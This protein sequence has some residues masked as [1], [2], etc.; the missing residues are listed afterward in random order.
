MDKQLYNIKYIAIYLT[1]TCCLASFFALVAGAS[2]FKAFEL[3]MASKDWQKTPDDQLTAELIT[4]LLE[5][6]SD[7]LW[8]T[9]ACAERIVNDAEVSQVLVKTGLRRSSR[10]IESIKGSLVSYEHIGDAEEPQ[11]GQKEQ[12]VSYF[13]SHERERKLCIL[14]RLL[15]DRLDRIQT[16]LLMSNAWKSSGTG[17][18]EEAEEEEDPWADPDED[19]PMPPVS[20]APFTLAEF[21]VQPLVDSGIILASEQRFRALDLL[22]NYHDQTI[23]PYRYSILDAI[24]LYVHP[25]EYHHLLPA[26]DYDTS[27]EVRETRKPWREKVDWVEEREVVDAVNK[28]AS[29]EEEAWLEGLE[30]PEDE[31]FPRTRHDKLLT[32]E[33]LT[34]WYTAR[35][36]SIDSQSGL[37]DN[38]LIFLQHGASQSVPGLDELGED[39]ILLDRL[40]YEAPQP[41]TAM[42]IDWDLPRWRQMQP[43]EV[44]RAYLAYSTYES[45]P[46]DI[47]SLVMPYLSVLE[48]QAERAKRPD[49][50]LATRLLYDYILEAPLELVVAI[51]EHS[52]ADV[53]RSYRIIKTDEDVAR[54]AMAYLYGLTKITDWPML[55]RIFECQPDWGDEREDDDEAFA[56]LTSLATFVAP[57]ASRASATAQELLL[58]FKPLPA[59]ALSRLL[60]VL[61]THLEGGEILSKWG[62]DTPLQWFLLSADNEAEQRSRAVRMSRRTV[63]QGAELEDEASWRTLFDDMIKLTSNGEGGVKPAFGRLSPAEI[64]KIFFTGLLSSGSTL[65]SDTW[66]EGILTSK[67]DFAVAKRLKGRGNVAKYLTGPVVEEICLNVS[68]ELYDNASSGNMHRGDMKLA[69][70][71]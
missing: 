54:V 52:K 45:I 55:S 15:F 43:R 5:D 62:V 69:Y 59:S 32:A 22:I 44:I 10:L 50:E 23:F 19:I 34:A 47:R 37:L 67:P 11:D 28:T 25:S 21:L 26:N 61:D 60:D 20:D 58:F 64:S 6:I 27:V 33:Q 41:D 49:L 12:L 46:S 30:T 51:F 57:S 38:A 71:W 39:L 65:F 4:E 70:E 63:H 8:V 17:E 3:A 13:E 31:E 42:Q 7:D 66:E 16:Y 29:K 56:T 9:A 18:E 24:P 36:A 1:Y 14:R 40:I 2:P 35:V 68:R 48:A 53:Q